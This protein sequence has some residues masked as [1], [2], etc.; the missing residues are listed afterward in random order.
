[1]AR[2]ADAEFAEPWQAEAFVL[3]IA[4]Q[5]TGHIT[6][7]EWSSTLSDEIE[8]ARAAG[9]LADGS[10]YYNHVVAALERLVA[11]KGV[12]A[13]AALDQRRHDWEE[14]YR[15]TPHGRPVVLAKDAASD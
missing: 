11:E 10:T 12:L 2:P 9:D 7:T 6:P 8:K 5:E 4:L 13:A 3:S 1:M 15:R 14:A